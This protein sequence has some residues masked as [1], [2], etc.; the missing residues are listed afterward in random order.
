LASQPDGAGHAEDHRPR[1]T[2]GETV[3]ETVPAAVAQIGHLTNGT[4]TP[5]YCSGA[6][7][8]RTW[9]GGRPR[10]RGHSA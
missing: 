9:E 3:A 1:P 7:A 2:A 10:T 5:S 8:L 6:T 4:P